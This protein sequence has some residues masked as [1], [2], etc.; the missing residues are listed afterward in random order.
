MR[1]ESNRRT[2]IALVVAWFA[3]GV[4]SV[5]ADEKGPVRDE[6]E[7]RIAPLVVRHCVACHNASD[8]K[9]GLDLTQGKGALVGGESGPAIVPGQPDESLLIER[10]RE[11]SMPPKGKGK[12][13]APPE[14]AALTAWVK[15]GAAW[16]DGRVLNPFE[17]T[18]E[19]RAGYDWWSLQPVRRPDVPDVRNQG[20][21]RTPIDAFVARTLEDRK[22][23]PAPEADRVTYI[24]RVTFDLIG[25]PP[26]PDEID[27][28][29]A[30]QSPGAY[31]T[32]ID[33]LLASPHYGERWGR[34]WLDV[35]R[36]GESDGFENDKLRGESW[37]Y[38]DY[39]IRSLNDDKPYRQFI[40]EQLAGDVL[41]P[42][43]RD[44]I[45]ASGFLVAGP[46]DEVQNVGKS[47]TEKLRAR[48]EQLE[49]LVAV[50]SQAFLGLTVNCSRCHDHKF[51]P[52][53]QTDYYRIK[54]IFEGVEHGNRPLFTPD[55][56]QAHDALVMP[57]LARV[58]ELRKEID[59]LVPQDGA[60]VV[61]RIPKEAFVNGRFGATFDPKKV[62]PTLRSKPVWN[63]PPW[64]VECWAQVNSKGAFNILVANNLKESSEH[65]EL[66]TYAG[67]GDLSLYLPGFEPAEIRSG[68]DVTD[69][70]WHYV[71]ATFDGEHAALFVDGKQA[72]A[73]TVKRQ[74]MGGPLGSLYFAAYPPQ[75][76]GCDGIVDEV[77]LSNVVRP[78]EQIPERAFAPDAQ[79]TGLWRF[80]RG[81]GERVR[82]FAPRPEAGGEG[83]TGS[84][85]DGEI[86]ARVAALREELKQRNAEVAAYPVP[87]VYAGVRRQPAPTVLFLRGD[88]RKPGPPVAP[89]A[90]SAVRTLTD[91]LGLSGESS[92]ADRRIRFADWVANAANPLTARVLVNRVWHYHFGQGLADMPSDLGFNG[93]LPSHPEL[94]DWLAAEFMEPTAVSPLQCKGGD[95]APWTLKRLHKLILLSAVYRQ[96]SLFNPQAAAID[97]DD[98][99]LW[100]F[101][102]RR[103]EAETI[104]DAMLAVSGELNPQ[105]GG[106]SFR[107]F[108]V[109]S[110][111]TQFYHLIDDGRAEFNRRTVYRINVNTAKSPFLDALDCPAPSLAAP[112]RRSTTTT[113]QALALMNDSFVERQAAK[114]AAR[115]A[116]AKGQAPG[117]V[118][119]VALAYRIVLGRTPTNDER[120]ATR[121]LV[122]EHGLETACWALLNTSEFLY[123]K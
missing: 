34:H 52:V 95:G 45:A 89:G 121:R 61:D 6:F 90:L 17:L 112:K 107:P 70:K 15:A 101:A 33:R 29:V 11:G 31:E 64:T 62:E 24:R 77:R 88:I 32:L 21:I 108:T 35:V 60:P 99:L 68:V 86:E 103:L 46:W 105:V 119:E 75:K 111:L 97:A 66:Y 76:I 110:I 42:V 84:G 36:F 7:T 20:W 55:E 104:R 27:A 43:T 19:Q 122:D 44:G 80:D 40:R 59:A 39:V 94:L 3:L 41:P 57:I 30:D 58:A 16:P 115:V 63:T 23:E 28:F 109:T 114:L 10:V 13:L 78:I 5:R 26:T 123:L 54:A 100:R 8:P 9:G 47:P 53:A 117:D 25:L 48:E 81:E 106:P 49:E 98:R 73:A 87:M 65:W 96:S 72:T 113:L 51:D 56:Q 37:R 74:R 93:G 85:G 91:D 50:V 82:D 12:R 14:I 92:E 71:A 69:G 22:L 4:H 38:R 118:D 67:T 120:A 2:S 1:I 116:D 18:T 79:T 83:E 102:P